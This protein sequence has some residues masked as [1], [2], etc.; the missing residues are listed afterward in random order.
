MKT[1]NTL[2]LKKQDNYFFDG[3]YMETMKESV[4]IYTPEQRYEK[5]I[6]YMTEYCGMPTQY[7]ERSREE[8]FPV[9]CFTDGDEFSFNHLEAVYYSFPFGKPE[10]HTLTIVNRK[11]TLLVE[12]NGEIFFSAGFFVI[13]ESECTS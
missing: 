10:E 7:K 12:R 2:S 4:Y 9:I 8:G 5:A 6:A 11:G 1:N 3:K 13:F